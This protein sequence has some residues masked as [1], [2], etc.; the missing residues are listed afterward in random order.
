MEA[1]GKE[2]LEPNS[3]S[4]MIPTKYIFHE[5]GMQYR[6]WWLLGHNYGM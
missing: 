3:L 4:Y 6:A 5:W 2:V 1:L